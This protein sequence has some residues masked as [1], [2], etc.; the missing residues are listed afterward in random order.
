M[1]V[2]FGMT[3][4]VRVPTDIIIGYGGL[5]SLLGDWIALSCGRVDWLT[6]KFIDW[7][8]GEPLLLLI[9]LILLGIS[10]TLEFYTVSIGVEAIR[11]LPGFLIVP[12]FLH[13]LYL[14]ECEYSFTHTH[15]EWLMVGG[16][17]QFQHRSW[18]DDQKNLSKK[19]KKWLDD[20][21]S[22]CG[23]SILGI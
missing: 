2:L 12:S 14:I 4:R 17:R 7:P 23:T 8:R 11:I 20:Q 22:L 21:N 6:K 9:N 19:N 13:S 10:Y 18:L 5:W 15:I 1:T 16:K 3:S